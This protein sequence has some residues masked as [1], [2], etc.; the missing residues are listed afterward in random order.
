MTLYD[1]QNQ[2][3][4]DI[5]NAVAD[6]SLTYYLENNPSRLTFTLIDDGSTISFGNGATVTLTYN[7]V[8][9]FKGY[10]FKKTRNKETR[11]VQVMCYDL[12]RYLQNSDAYVFE[13]KSSSEIFTQICNDFALPSRVTD[14]SSYICAP[15]VEDNKTLYSM[16][17]NAL[18]DTLYNTGQWFIIR[19]NFG[20][21]E[22]V[23]IL[24]LTVGVLLGDASGLID[25]TYDETIDSRTYNQIKLYRDNSATN[26]RDLY[27]VNDSVNNGDTIRWWGILQ[28]YQKVDDAINESQIESLALGLLNYYN[29]PTQSISLQCLGVPEIRAGSIFSASI[30]NLGDTTLNGNLIVDEVTHTISNNQHTMILRTEFYENV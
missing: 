18:D 23:N 24:N 26:S 29:R 15:R 5:S 25:F 13:G 11:L 2:A 17:Q 1:N 14:A 3:A 10:V 20:T 8:N 22:H 7:S 27:I 19:D 21:L 6:I 16:I 30:A 9:M 4:Y 28:L 12:L